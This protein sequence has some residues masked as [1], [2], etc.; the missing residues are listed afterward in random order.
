MMMM[1]M[2]IMIP[3]TFTNQ[4][5]CA[6]DVDD[7]AVKVPLSKIYSL[8]SPLGYWRSNGTRTVT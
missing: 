2:V 7:N 5:L 1:M 6:S 8:R 4:N 3:A